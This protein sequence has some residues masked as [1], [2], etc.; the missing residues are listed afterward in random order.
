MG[1]TTSVGRRPTMSVT[2]CHAPG[3]AA[4]TRVPAGAQQFWGGPPGGGRW[5][6]RT[7]GG[8]G[9]KKTDHEGQ[10]NRKILENWAEG[11]FPPFDR[12]N[13]PLPQVGR[14]GLHG[15]TSSTDAPI[16]F[17]AVC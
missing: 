17:Y 10:A 11:V 4:S 9:L 13:D 16:L 14:V 15:L 8:V 3:V 12:H 2:F 5:W 1:A 7:G 6:Q